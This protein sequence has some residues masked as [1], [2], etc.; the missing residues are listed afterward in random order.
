M[1][2]REAISPN[3]FSFS[4]V[5]I[6]IIIIISWLHVHSFGFCSQFHLRFFIA[7]SKS[8]SLRP[9]QLFVF[10]HSPPQ[11]SFPLL[12]PG[13]SS[14][15]HLRVVLLWP[16]HSVCPLFDSLH[17]YRSLHHLFSRLLP[18]PN[19][20]NFLISFHFTIVFP[21]F[22][23]LS[24]ILLLLLLF[25]SRSALVPLKYK[26]TKCKWSASTTTDEMIYDVRARRMPSTYHIQYIY[27]GTCSSEAD[28]VAQIRN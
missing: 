21:R 17:L 26:N 1:V 4:S 3:F 15:F 10:V 9:R 5:A 24:F 13:F 18:K 22:F 16:S 27:I 14:P 28:M 19:T 23:F 6:I 7:S 12:P 8:M 20:P 11:N 25:A 2:R